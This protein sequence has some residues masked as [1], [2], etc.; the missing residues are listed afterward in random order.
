MPGAIIHTAN[1]SIGYI[2][3]K[4]EYVVQNKLNLNVFRGELVCLIG[5]NGCGKSTLLRSLAGLQPVLE[6]EIIIEGRPIGKQTLKDK[7]R[8]IGLVLTDR[9]EVSNLTVFQLIALGRNPYTDWLGNLSNEDTEKIQTAIEQVHLKGYEQRFLNELSDGERQRTMIAKALVQDTPVILLDEPT[10]HLDLPNRVEIMIL[11]RSLA[12][13]TNKAV[14]LSTHELD[15]ALQASDKLWL[16]SPK[17]GIAV[18]T[19]ED[20][21][22]SNHLQQVFA[23]NSFYFDNKTGN[24]VMKH[25]GS[26]HT[27]SLVTKGEGDR[28]FWTQR[29]LT[30]NGYQFSDQSSVI[31]TV[32]ENQNSWT[33]SAPQLNKQVDSLEELLA[34]LA[35]LMQISSQ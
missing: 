18:G 35:P 25:V 26:P 9:V 1:L 4:E 21:I 27:V 15:L 10:A 32:D 34:L 6:G 24:F 33:L 12:K 14:V 5:P 17:G 31:V 22:L 20:L 29:A 2:H 16:M 7:A 3:R 23:N 28:T 13:K 19:P 8:L 11:L 30:R